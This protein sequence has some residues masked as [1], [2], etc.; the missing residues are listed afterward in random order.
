MIQKPF[1]IVRVADAST[2]RAALDLRHRVF[3]EEQSI[4]AE[5]DEDGWDERSCHLAIFD[6]EHLVATGRWRETPAE[7]ADLSRIAVSSEYRGHG[8]GAMVVKNL[9]IWAKEAGMRRAW[10]EPHVHLESFYRRFGFIRVGEAHTVGGH[11][12]L[13]MECDLTH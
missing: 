11:P 13:R 10:L 3:V 5:L 4:P 12:L 6:G 7:H 2:L 8:L 1:R 9:L